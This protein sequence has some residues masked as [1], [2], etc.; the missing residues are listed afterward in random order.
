MNPVNLLLQ[1]PMSTQLAPATDDIQL[2]HLLKQDD[3]ATAVAEL[4]DELK[5]RLQHEIKI[6][7]ESIADPVV[8]ELVQN[9]FSEV[10][11]IFNRLSL[12][13]QKL[14]ELDTLQ[15]N[16][17]ILELLQFEIRYLIEF[18]EARAMYTPG[19]DQRL[20][21][22]FD[23][24]SYGMS[25]DVK[26][27]FE[28]ELTSDIRNKSIPVVYGKILHAHG[29]LSNCFQQTFI[30]LL[31][32]LNPK[33]DPLDLFDDFEERLRQ[34]LLLCNELS[35]L[36]RVVKQAESQPTPEVLQEVVDK[37]LE[38]RDGSMQYLMYRD[39]R[40]YEHHS[41]ALIT[42]IQSNLDSKNLLH[43]FACYLE[44]LY[45]H[46]K[47]RAVIRDLFPQSNDESDGDLDPQAPPLPS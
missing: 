12:I 17:S 30:T 3:D 47:M 23:G 40:G 20:L 42:S 22:T 11:R 26:R 31:Q 36:M 45:G 38:F 5:A 29:L 10:I 8:R 21:E 1:P 6:G 18:I 32:V 16:L 41:L 19:V 28:R 15:E 24:I 9:I 7:L 27:V 2:H 25:H 46:V 37:S 43:Q 13:Q 4:S 44:V 14:N 33:L 39:W 35:A 34:S